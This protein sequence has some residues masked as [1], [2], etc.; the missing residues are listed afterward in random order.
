ML[1]CSRNHHEQ[2]I[3]LLVPVPD[4]LAFQLRQ[5][6]VA[7]VQL[8]DDLRMP[9]LR[10]QGEFRGQVNRFDHARG[11]LSTVDCST[12]IK[13]LADLVAAEMLLKVR[14]AIHPHAAGPTPGQPQGYAQLAPGQRDRRA[15]TKRPHSAASTTSR[16]TPSI[17]KEHGPSCR[18]VVEDLIRIR[19]LVGLDRLQDCDAGVSSR[20][21]GRHLA[22]RHRR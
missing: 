11:L 3:F 22:L 9:I 15:A 4:E 13:L 7:V 17:A 6:D 1:Q 12:S 18:H 2:L 16:I 5:L 19:G 8:T 20:Q 10:E 21:H 14:L